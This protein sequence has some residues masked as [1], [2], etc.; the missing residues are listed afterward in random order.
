MQTNK[1]FFFEVLVSHYNN[2]IFLH[3]QIQGAPM[4]I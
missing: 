2:N 3:W 1:S 4:L